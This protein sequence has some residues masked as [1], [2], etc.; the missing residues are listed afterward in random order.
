MST[1][2]T[3]AS[4]ILFA[5]FFLWLG[6]VIRCQRHDGDGREDKDDDKASDRQARDGEGGRDDIGENVEDSRQE[7]GDPDKEDKSQHDSEDDA[8]PAGHAGKPAEE[9]PYHV[10]SRWCARRDLNPWHQAS[11]AC[12][13]SRL[14]YGRNGAPSKI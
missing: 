7:K 1:N 10:S 4:T 14:S 11:E 8:G 13:L 2:S 9:F 3:T 5:L 6:P 12:A